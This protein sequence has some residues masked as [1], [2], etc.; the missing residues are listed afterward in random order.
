MALTITKTKRN[1]VSGSKITA[2][3]Q[4]TF[5]NSY[6]TGGEAFDANAQSGLGNIDEIRMTAAEP[7]DVSMTFAYDA[8]NKKI[9]AYGST[10][11]ASGD[12]VDAGAATLAG[13]EVLLELANASA[14]LN[15]YKLDIAISGSR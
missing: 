11:K 6:P 12:A 9:L 10:T 14:V 3:L 8:T 1:S 13:G 4:V 5:D 15:N 7:T 2:Y